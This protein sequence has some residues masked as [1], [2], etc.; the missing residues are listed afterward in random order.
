[1]ASKTEK[2]AEINEAIVEA[3][4]SH[5]ARASIES[6]RICY[7]TRLDSSFGSYWGKASF[8]DMLMHMNGPDMRRLSRRYGRRR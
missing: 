4:M 7:S 2:V 6:G 1:M 8:G 5:R 3:G